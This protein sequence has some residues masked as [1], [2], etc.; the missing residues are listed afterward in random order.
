MVAQ[1]STAARPHRRRTTATGLR[2]LDK[3]TCRRCG[4]TGHWAWDCKNPKEGKEQ[5]HL[6][7]ADDDEPMILMT[8][9]CALKEAVE[10][11]V[12]R[13]ERSSAEWG[14]AKQSVSL[15]ESCT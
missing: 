11:L 8:E 1:G 9:L 10:E 4:K 3:D 13:E 7:Q 6:A 5:V 14:K 12:S 15:D 2:P